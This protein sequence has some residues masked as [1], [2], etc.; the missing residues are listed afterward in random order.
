MGTAFSRGTLTLLL[1]AH[2]LPAAAAG[3][4]EEFMRVRAQ[5][6]TSTELAID[7]DS[8]LLKR[9]DGFYTSGAMLGQRFALL[10]EGGALVYGWRISQAL[11]TNSNINLKP[12]Q[13]GSPDHPYAGWLFGGVFREV[14]GDDGTT[15]RYGI[16]LG[17][18]GPCAGGEWSQTALHRILRQKLPQGWAKQVRNEVGVVLDVEASPWRWRRGPQLDLAPNFHGR[19]GNIFTDAGAGLTLRAGQLDFNP[20]RSSLHFYLRADVDAVG[21]NATLQGG[22]FSRDNPHTV[23]P[24]RLVGEA[25]LGA[26]LRDGAIGVRASVV[27]RG[28]E[29]SGLPNSI[30]TQNFV[31]L[32]FSYAP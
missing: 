9:D 29:I 15:L 18:L 27:R 4:G 22:Y 28:N 16:D 3:M 14:R 8:L 10:R 7:N 32:L 25:E 11:Y 6:V 21:H 2:S 20:L 1:T 31:R 26:E 12:E 5:G 19:F 30:G 13:F 17:C 23:A 24:K